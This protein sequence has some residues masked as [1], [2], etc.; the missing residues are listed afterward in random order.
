MV[1]R[2]CSRQRGQTQ[3]GRCLPRGLTP[4][5]RGAGSSNHRAPRPPP[6]PHPEPRA[7]LSKPGWGMESPRGS[8]SGA[9]HPEPSAAS[10][11]TLCLPG[12]PGTTLAPTGP[13]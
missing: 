12:H 13:P 2:A 5:S 6:P 4:V 8:H 1:P 11:G 10:A 9:Q 3:R 7:L